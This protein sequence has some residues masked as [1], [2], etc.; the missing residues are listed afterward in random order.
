M[1]E[2]FDLSLQQ[3]QEL[4]GLLNLYGPIQVTQLRWYNHT[5]R[6]TCQ[7]QTF[8]L[9]LHNKDWYPPDEG[10]TGYSVAH[11]VSAWSILARYDLATPEVVMACQNRDNPLGR[12]FLL[13][14]EVPGTV[15]ADLLPQVSPQEVA[16]MLHAVGMYLRRMHTIQFAYAGYILGE[17]PT[18]PPHEGSWQ[19][20]TWTLQACQ[21][22]MREWVQEHH[23]ELSSSLLLQLEHMAQTL[24]EMLAPAYMVPRFTQGDCWID[25]IIMVQKHGSWQISAFLDMEVASAGDCTFD[26]VSLCQGLA[27]TLPSALC[28]W[29]PLFEGYGKEPDFA[30]FRL[31]L[32]GGWYPYEAN[33]WPGVGEN[34]FRHLLQAED[35][36][37]LFSR[38]HLPT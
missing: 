21:Q 34:S 17:G 14:R 5:Y 35:W 24:P 12:S 30:G 11:E 25:Q 18:A 15:L 33:I 27:Q 9:K 20:F 28:W 22:R 10:E 6:I 37:T 7:D 38:A 4:M 32:S 23:A 16:E 1:P 8:Y 19:H 31:R 29:Q 13:T 2:A 26:L 36:E 3:T